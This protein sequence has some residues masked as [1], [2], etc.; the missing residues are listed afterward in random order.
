MIVVDASVVVVAL[1]DDGSDGATIRG[2]LRD[3]QLV[4]PEVLDLEVLSAWRKMLAA[5]RLDEPR[6][7]MARADLSELPIRRIPHKSLLERSWELRSN[8]T[9]YD[10]AYVA[11]A[12]LLDAPLVTGDRRLAGAPGMRCPVEVW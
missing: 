12:E 10:G 8:L 3:R 6:A 5:G 7:R 2:R 1:V 11:L 9:I 4:A